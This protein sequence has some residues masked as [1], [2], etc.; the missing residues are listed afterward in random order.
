MPVIDKY[1][2]GTFCWVELSTT[3]AKAAKG[4]YSGLFGWTT[5]DMPIG[6][7]KFYTM[8]KL[9]GQTVGALYEAGEEMAGIPPNWLSYASVANVDE[10]AEKVGSLGGKV[11][12]APFD[13]MDAGRMAVI[14]DPSDAAFALWQ[15]NKSFGATIVNDP[16][17]FCWNE[18]L[19]RD[20]A[21]CKSFYTGLFGW[22]ANVMEGGPIPYTIFLNGERPAGGMMDMPAEAGPAPSHWLVYFSV[23]DADASVKKVEELGGSIRVPPMDIPNVGRFSVVADPQGAGFGIIKLLKIM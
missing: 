3:D 17:S 14:L 23:E 22:T 4:F 12:K 6:P 20:T 13:V 1:V 5:D 18:L 19:T 10:T 7:D 11:M 8:L 2:P 9:D 21:A 16:G 15:A